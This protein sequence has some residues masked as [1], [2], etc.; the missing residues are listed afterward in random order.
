[1]RL[2]RGRFFTAALAILLLSFPGVSQDKEKKRKAASLDGTTGLFKTWDAET[3][4]YDEINF[5]A[6]YSHY[7]RDPGELSIKTVP[8]GLSCIL[9]SLL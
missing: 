8:V 5:S 6:G 4:R 9:T 3:L 1:M 2:K 7:N